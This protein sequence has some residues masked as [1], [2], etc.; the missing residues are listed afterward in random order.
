MWGRTSFNSILPAD[1]P[2]S[3]GAR[4]RCEVRP[5]SL[6]PPSSA[7]PAAPQSPHPPPTWTEPARCQVDGQPFPAILR[8]SHPQPAAPAEHGSHCFLC[9]GRRRS[10]EPRTQESGRAGGAQLAQVTA[11]SWLLGSTDGGEELHVSRQAGP[12]VL[13]GTRTGWAPLECWGQGVR[14]GTEGSR[15][16]RERRPASRS[17]GGSSRIQ[18]AWALTASPGIRGNPDPSCAWL[19]PSRTLRVVPLRASL[20][21]S[22]VGTAFWPHTRPALPWH[23]LQQRCPLLLPLRLALIFSVLVSPLAASL[24]PLSRPA[25]FAYVFAFP[26]L[27]SHTRK[28][29]FCVGGLSLQQYLPWCCVHEGIEGMRTWRK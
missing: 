17:P 3:W 2:L 29:G 24:A 4:A 19:P 27:V 5:S 18:T 8:A 16:V 28:A 22:C 20:T 21:L 12:I 7:L 15:G 13:R 14:R 23:L 9:G 26:L 11:R 6:S 1:G 10:V 25:L